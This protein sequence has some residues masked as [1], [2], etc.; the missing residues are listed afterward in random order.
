MVNVATVLPP[1]VGTAFAFARRKTVR[2]NI[3]VEFVLPNRLSRQTSVYTVGLAVILTA[4]S[5]NQ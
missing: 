4:V 2:E 1:T 3:V 5:L